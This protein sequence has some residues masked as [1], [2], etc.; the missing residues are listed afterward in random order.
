LNSASKRGRKSAAAGRLGI[1]NLL[2]LLIEISFF[3]IEWRDAFQ[4]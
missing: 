4:T 2:G 3:V 1:E